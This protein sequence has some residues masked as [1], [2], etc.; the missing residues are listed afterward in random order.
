M[1]PDFGKPV[2]TM[3]SGNPPQFQAPRNMRARRPVR[4]LIE[5]SR[6]V[7]SGATF[8]GP[9]LF[10]EMPMRAPSSWLPSILIGAPFRV[11]A[12]KIADQQTQREALEL[13][14]A[15]QKLMSAEQF[16]RAADAFSAAIAKDG[17]LTAA[18]YGLGQAYMNLQRF[19][20]A[21]ECLHGLH[22]SVARSAL[23]AA[24][25]SIRRRQAARRRDPGAERS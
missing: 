20:D 21:A 18:H 12:Q 2:N 5:A 10:S 22:R 1:N 16:D 11:E 25:E 14:R 3:L 6:T 15:G 4:V 24:D 7:R 9:L 13:L 19:A 23:A 8:G 17:L